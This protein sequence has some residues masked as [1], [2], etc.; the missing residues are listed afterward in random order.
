MTKKKGKLIVYTQE[1]EI[2]IEEH[3]IFFGLGFFY[4]SVF[5]L[6]MGPPHKDFAIVL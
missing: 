3:I 6:P 4:I 2:H 1:E 5:H